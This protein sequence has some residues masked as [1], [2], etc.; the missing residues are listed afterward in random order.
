MRRSSLIAIMLACLAGPAGAETLATPFEPTSDPIGEI[1]F[2]TDPGAMAP[3]Y[4]RALRLQVGDRPTKSQLSL[5]LERLSA[6]PNLANVELKQSGS[7]LTLDFDEHPVSSFLV[8]PV[9]F[10]WMVSANTAFRDWRVGD[11]YV[12]SRAELGYMWD[13]LQ[14][15]DPRQAKPTP[16]SFNNDYVYGIASAGL[17]L[18]PDLRL[19]LFGEGYV[20]DVQPDGPGA[21]LSSTYAPQAQGRGFSLTL[22]PELRYDNSD[23]ETFPRLGTR[24]RV[25]SYFGSPYL[26]G[27]SDYAI[28]RGELQRYSPLGPSE[29]VVTGIRGGMGRGE[30]PW[31]H[32]F[33]AGGSYNLRGYPYQ[34]F[35]GDQMLVGTLEYRRRLATDLVPGWV[36]GLGLTGGAFVDVGR[37]W[38]AR[39]GTP[40]PQDIRAG[41]GGY[42]GFTLGSWNMG[43]I[44][45][46]YGTE[47]PYVGMAAGLPFDW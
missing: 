4:L 24:V 17:L 21:A 20:S 32:K 40:F 9:P 12:S 5:A 36:S 34:R 46:S 14:V 3:R 38:E 44:E 37:V 27:L 8:V 43:R 7:L 45:A 28:Y 18:A 22:G 19:Q 23:D 41:A 33:W 39:F 29:T 25:G 47:G 6:L 26:G 15:Y 35:L 16:M 10:L 30:L 11:F 31:N 2:A 42:L 1:E 13:T